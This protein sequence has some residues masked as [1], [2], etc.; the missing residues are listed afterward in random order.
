M[1][2]RI[3]ILSIDGGG[4]RGVIPITI[5]EYIERITNRK[6]FDIFDHFVGTSTGGILSIMLSQGLDLEVIKDFYFGADCKKIFTANFIRNPLIYKY[7]SSAIEGVLRKTIG[8]GSFSEAKKP[9]TVTFYDTVTSTA[10]IISSTDKSASKF[11]SWE[12]ARA[13]SAAPTY[14]EP[15][16][17]NNMVAI[18]GGMFANNP[19]FCGYIEARKIFGKD[20]EFI[21]LSLGTGVSNSPSLA[22]KIKNFTLLDW[23]MNLFDLTSD[24]YSD[25]VAYAMNELAEVDSHYRFTPII[26]EKNTGVDD[27]TDDNLNKLQQITNN[28]I[29]TDWSNDLQKMIQDI[30]Y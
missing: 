25:T 16:S 22:N 26:P 17:F 11:K 21:I 12:C 2:K 27:T 23:G 8:E 6:I 13:T 29:A 10:K 15:F 5:L 28:M 24:G 20:C 18:D 3:K 1:V 19:T 14:F 7:P 4:V 30:L 9:C